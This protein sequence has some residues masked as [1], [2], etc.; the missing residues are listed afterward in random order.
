VGVPVLFLISGGSCHEI[1]PL[2]HAADCNGRVTLGVLDERFSSDPSVNN[3]LQFSGTRFFREAV[4]NGAHDI[5]SIPK[6]GETVGQ[7]ALRLDT[8]FKTWR[9]HNPTGVVIALMGFGRDGHTAGIMRYPG[10]QHV[11][12]KLFVHTDAWAVGYDAGNR[13]PVP[14]RA[15]VTVPFLL[16]VDHAVFYVAG[17]EKQQALKNVFDP[18]G[19]IWTTPGR[20]IHGMK[21]CLLFTDQSVDKVK[22]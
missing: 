2:L 20:I 17:P 7:L 1:T 3:Y 8:S 13:N 22:V 11:F 16:T 6:P 9:S 19:D 15:T 4:K 21:H 18:R 12:E 5:P 14:V 10:E